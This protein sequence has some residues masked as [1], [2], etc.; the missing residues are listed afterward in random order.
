M[1]KKSFFS[2]GLKSLLALGLVCLAPSLSKAEMKFTTIPQVSTGFVGKSYP[3]DVY[4]NSTQHPTNKIHYVRWQGGFS[5]KFDKAEL[6]AQ[7]QDFFEGLTMYDGHNQLTSG[8]SERLVYRDSEH[9]DYGATNKNRKVGTVWMS[10]DD[11]GSFT[12][13]PIGISISDTSN[14]EYTL[15]RKN[16]SVSNMPIKILARPE[17][18]SLESITGTNILHFTYGDNKQASVS[19]ST[20]DNVR[21]EAYRIASSENNPNQYILQSTTNLLGN[22]WVERVRG[23]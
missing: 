15:G 3:F 13:S 6:P 10:F 1:Q 4:I 18:K 21:F 2:A 14:G 20:N 16:L 9:V 17:L 11:S 8:S 22:N 23:Q 7:A 12:Y 19:F 5:G